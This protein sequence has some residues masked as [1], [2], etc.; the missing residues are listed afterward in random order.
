MKIWSRSLLVGALLVAAVFLKYG[1][2]HRDSLPVHVNRPQN[3]ATSSLLTTSVAS[4]LGRGDQASGSAAPM[5]LSSVV[6]VL[7]ARLNGTASARELATIELLYDDL[8]V[9]REALERSLAKREVIGSDS[10]LI[11]IPEYEVQGRKMF[12]DF[13]DEVSRQTEKPKSSELITELTRSVKA[14]NAFFGTK[15]QQIL[16]ERKAK[17]FHVVHKI[18]GFTVF[19]GN[20]LLFTRTTI[21]DLLPQQLGPYAFLKDLFPQGG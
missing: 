20:P 21:S 4:D 13:V 5:K 1:R 18:G 7:S 17:A 15:E 2:H 14:D 9:R 12:D 6:Q 16:V 3:D 8:V 11:T 19:P 10:V